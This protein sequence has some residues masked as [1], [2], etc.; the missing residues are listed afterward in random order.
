MTSVLGMLAENAEHCIIF[1]DA[2]RQPRVDALLT[3]QK[4]L[5][6][7]HFIAYQQQIAWNCE[8]RIIQFLLRIL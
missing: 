5:S 3:A 8:S 6:Y 4:N 7:S 2:E 1:L